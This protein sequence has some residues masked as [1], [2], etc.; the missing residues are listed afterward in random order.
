MIL[1]KDGRDSSLGLKVVGGQPMPQGGRGAIIEKVK[2][3]SIAERE[4]GLRAGKSQGLSLP[5]LLSN[6]LVGWVLGD[7]VIEWNGRSLQGKGYEQVYEIVA[8]SRQEPQVELIVAR[9][10]T[11]APQHHHSA[12]E[13][14]RQGKIARIRDPL[15]SNNWPF[16]LVVLGSLFYHVYI[17]SVDSI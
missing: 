2:R 12:T 3:G 5:G 15:R 9:Q 10:A 8:E 17:L 13:L 4:G 16:C 14:W 1:K 11:R 7:E 6:M